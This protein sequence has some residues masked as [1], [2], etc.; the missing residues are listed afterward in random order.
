M[1][2]VEAA[3]K[4]LQTMLDHLG[5]EARIDE[6]EHD[7]SVCLQIRTEE[8]KYLIGA[9]GDRLEDF[10]YLVNRILSKHFPDAKRIRVDCDHYR[11]RYEEKIIQTARELAQKVHEDG[12]ARKMKPLNAFYRRLVHNA[13]VEDEK[14]KTSSPDGAARYKRV[15][16]QR[17]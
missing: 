11:D 4:I 14:V 1:T 2:E 12:K 13:L 5:F 17:S 9:N 10:Q 6:L 16:I 15:I 8:G 3:K 7:G